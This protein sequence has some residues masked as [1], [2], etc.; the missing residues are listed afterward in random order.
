MLMF[1]LP[2]VPQF[3]EVTMIE[4]MALTIAAELWLLFGGKAGR[5]RCLLR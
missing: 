4:V 2:D 3:V 5:E 1:A